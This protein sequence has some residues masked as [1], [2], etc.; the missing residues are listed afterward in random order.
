MVMEVVTE[1]LDVRDDVRH[2]LRCQVSREQDLAQSVE[3]F[4]K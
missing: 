1:R 3:N 2:A 4:K